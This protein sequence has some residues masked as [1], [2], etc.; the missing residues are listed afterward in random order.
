MSKEPVPT[1]RM[2][3][4]VITRILD[5]P[6]EQVWKAWTD[7]QLVRRWWGPKYYTSPDC[8]IDLREG[9]RYIFGM[10]AP[11]EQG[12]GDSYTSGVYKRIIPMQLLEFTQSLSDKDGSPVDPLQMG[13]PPDFPKEIRTVVTFKRVHEV[14]TELTV[15][16]YGW[17][18]G[19]MAVYS[20]AGMHQS[21]DKLA[22]NLKHS[23]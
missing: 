12:G 22:E 6:L 10:R 15:I 3:D 23:V 11:Q 5:A 21:L 14:L 13:M 1:V 7:P 4:L 18:P 8:R 16:E 2:E 20:L 9:G 17:K 19:Q